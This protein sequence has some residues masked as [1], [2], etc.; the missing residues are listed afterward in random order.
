MEDQDQSPIRCDYQLFLSALDL[1]NHGDWSSN[2]LY[3]Q[4]AFNIQ[5]RDAITSK[6]MSRLHKVNILLQK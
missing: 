3:I 1:V 2:V 4:C 5:S 6:N